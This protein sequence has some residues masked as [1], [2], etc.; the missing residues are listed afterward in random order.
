MSHLPVDEAA[1]RVVVCDLQ[2]EMS[3][4]IGLTGKS[5]R[6]SWRL[7]GIYPLEGS[8][9]TLLMAQRIRKRR[10]RKTKRTMR[11]RSRVIVRL[12][13]AVSYMPAFSDMACVN[14]TCMIGHDKI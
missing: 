8:A 6:D 7:I 9:L 13:D 12:N 10:K 1:P 11:R 2:N 14:I 3:G 5:G 4:L